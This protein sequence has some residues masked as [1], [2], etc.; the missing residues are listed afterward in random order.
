MKKTLPII[1]GL[2]LITGGVAYAQHG[3]GN[4]GPPPGMHGPHKGWQHGHNGKHHMPPP[5]PAAPLKGKGFDLELGHGKSLRVQ[6]ADEKMS[7]CMAAVQPLVRAL[8]HS[9][10]HHHHGHHGHRPMPGQGPA[11]DAQPGSPN[12]SS[13]TNSDQGSVEAP[14]SAAGTSGSGSS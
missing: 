4:D 7:D 12:Q 6:C 10:Q 14:D 8:E 1:V 5:P 9:G 11:G 3:D 2:A 13:D